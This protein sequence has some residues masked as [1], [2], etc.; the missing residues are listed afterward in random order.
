MGREIRKVP[1]D[2]QH[3]KNEL[4]GYQVMFEMSYEEALAEYKKDP[5]LYDYVEPDPKYYNT[6]YDPKNATCYQIY[7]TVSEGTPVSP[8][9]ETKEKLALYLSKNGDFWYQ[10]RRAK[11]RQDYKPTYEQALAFVNSGFAFSG[12]FLDKQVLTPYEQK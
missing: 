11:G 6:F 5:E 1:K 3:P 7:E 8:A 4:G 10:R 12:V 2:W 9:F